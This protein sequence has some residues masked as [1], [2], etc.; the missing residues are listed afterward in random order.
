MTTTNVSLSMVSLV[1]KILFDLFHFD[2]P[3]LRSAESS[4]Q[5]QLV[6]MFHSLRST[7]LVHRLSQ[8]SLFEIDVTISPIL[9]CSTTIFS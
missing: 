6:E 3:P 4:D 5:Q 9:L 7:P 8:I 2:H 1:M